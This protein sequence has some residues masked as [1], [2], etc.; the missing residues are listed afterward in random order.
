MKKILI[1][2][3]SILIISASA[4]NRGKLHEPAGQGDLEQVK[5]MIEKGAKV[6]KKDIAGQTPLMYAAETGKIDVVTYLIDQGADVNAVSGKMGRGTAIIYAAAANQVE[7]VEYLIENGAD[8]NATTPYHN[9]TALIWA[10]AQG[11][12]EVAKILLEH[13]ADKNIKTKQGQDVLD[14]AK[15][16]NKKEMI[17]LLEEN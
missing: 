6:D 14:L 8:I 13:G 2:L 7:T 9:E 15:Q 17:I 1:F 3:F 11:N 16:L 12:T 5:K 10:V 4:Q